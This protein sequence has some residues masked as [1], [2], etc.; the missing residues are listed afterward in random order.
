[1]TEITSG[2]NFF[3]GGE[4]AELNPFSTVSQASCY[5]SISLS[6]QFFCQLVSISTPGGGMCIWPRLFPSL[7]ITRRC[8]FGA[9]RPQTHKESARKGLNGKNLGEITFSAKCV[10]S[11]LPQDNLVTKKK[12][13]FRFIHGKRYL[14][15]HF[16]TA[17]AK[18]TNNIGLL[19]KIETRE[20]S[21][22]A[23]SP[24]A[25]LHSYFTTTLKGSCGLGL[26]PGRF[27]HLLK[28][29]LEDILVQAQ[30][31]ATA[32]CAQGRVIIKSGHPL[33]LATTIHTLVFVDR[34]NQ[35]PI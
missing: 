35:P 11:C 10:L 25:F 33:V 23:P 30:H 32:L 2:G 14:Q 9:Y 15:N 12:G 1:M 16:L 22:K 24:G 17:V 3:I 19:E 28:V 34:H 26:R 5:P 29:R 13:A 31:Q 27:G 21:K 4:S 6:I 20:K 7:T 8:W 18:H